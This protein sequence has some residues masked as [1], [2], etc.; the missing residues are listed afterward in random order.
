M[1]IVRAVGCAVSQPFYAES[2]A[3]IHSLYVAAQ[4]FEHFAL[5]AHH[6]HERDFVPVRLVPADL[7]H[8]AELVEKHAVG[9]HAKR[10][11]GEFFQD[12]EPLGGRRACGDESLV[13]ESPQRRARP[14]EP[15]TLYVLAAARNLDA[16]LMPELLVEIRG[17]VYE[18]AVVIYYYLSAALFKFGDRLFEGLVAALL[19][20]RRVVGIPRVVPFLEP[21]E[22]E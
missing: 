5:G 22:Q 10:A 15:I 2:R 20:F 4:L 19:R 6:L 1:H 9:T 12:F 8:V 17:G 16:Y 7:A 13:A 14:A 21:A 3:G 18:L 11:V